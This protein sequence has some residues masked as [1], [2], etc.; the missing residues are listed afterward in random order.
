MSTGLD[1]PGAR[2]TK[3]RAV[4]VA[5]TV[6][7]LA[8]SLAACG[9]SSAATAPVA[10]SSPASGGNGFGGGNGSGRSFPGT[11]GTIAAVDGT[12]LQVQSRTA[13]TAVTFTSATKFTE[14]VP[15][16]VATG[17]C[18]VVSG[19]PATTGPGLTAATVRVSLPV[20]GQCAT[21]GFGGFGG[22]GRPRP[23]GSPPAGATGNFADRATAT[24]T[25]QS[26]SATGFVLDGFLRQFDSGTGTGASPS[27]SPTTSPITV[28]TDSSTVVT[29]IAATTSAAAK[30][31][32]CAT[33]IGVTSSTGAVAA[34]SISLSAPTSNG[35]SAGFGRFGGGG[36]GGQGGTSG[37][38]GGVIGG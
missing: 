15:G 23:S 16:H 11:T 12:T 25:V 31:G 4:V 24:G 18:V 5:C 37:G 14:S 17:D 27:A 10:N 20:N 9:T 38:Q 36:S 8:L 34:K 2:W 33:A 35:C 32:M 21:R 1:R 30:V 22:A 28:D 29:T 26:V 19:A 3:S 7:V 6:P 13:Q